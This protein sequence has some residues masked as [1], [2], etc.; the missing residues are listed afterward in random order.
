MTTS[1]ATAPILSNQVLYVHEVQRGNPLLKHITN[2]R[3]EFSKEIVP[4]YVM[5]STCALFL[6]VRYHYRHPKVSSFYY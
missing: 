3:W 6:S 4:D 1:T 5:Q 2:T